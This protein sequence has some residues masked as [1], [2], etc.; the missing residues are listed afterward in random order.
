MGGGVGGGSFATADRSAA[1]SA[2]AI[3]NGFGMFTAPPT[4]PFVGDPLV[5][6][7][8]DATFANAATAA[9]SCENRHKSP[10][11]HVPLA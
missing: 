1:F 2:P 3:G 4:L 8:G 5:D 6:P 9:T 10:R 7:L 11:L